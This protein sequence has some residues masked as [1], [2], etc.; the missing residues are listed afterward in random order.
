MV[1]ANSP[2][3]V[4]KLKEALI[5]VI[6]EGYKK[7]SLFIKGTIYFS[8]LY[9]FEGFLF[10]SI[11]HPSPIFDTLLHYSASQDVETFCS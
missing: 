8:L 11:S 7:R 2:R 5:S 4:A 1:V 3:N 9:S 6:R 10:S